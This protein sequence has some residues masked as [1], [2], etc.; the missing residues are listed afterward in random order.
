MKTSVRPA[1]SL[2]APTSREWACDR[3]WGSHDYLANGGMCQ[4]GWE[5]G[6]WRG[7]QSSRAATLSGTLCIGNCLAWRNLSYF[8]TKKDI[9]SVLLVFIFI[10]FFRGHIVSTLVWKSYSGFGPKPIKFLLA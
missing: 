4:W 7:V 2:T 10:I 5:G 1:G 9:L 6:S 8:Y 3:P